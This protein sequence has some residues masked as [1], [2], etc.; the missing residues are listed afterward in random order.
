MA[1]LSPARPEICVWIF[2]V[3]NAML[4]LCKWM[5]WDQPTS[6]LINHLADSSHLKE[7]PRH[8]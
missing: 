2:L 8:S 7:E 5:G 3:M 1:K 6:P 4:E